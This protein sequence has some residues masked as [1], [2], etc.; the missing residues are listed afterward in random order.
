ME[1]ISKEERD[2][3]TKAV[4]KRLKITKGEPTME[5]MISQG[6]ESIFLGEAVSFS[7]NVE[8]E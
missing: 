2:R 6:G 8:Y 7:A 5:V 3:L 4:N 1:N